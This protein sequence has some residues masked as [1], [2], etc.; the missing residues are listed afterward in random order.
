MQNPNVDLEKN[1]AHW[2]VVASSGEV[3]PHKFSPGSVKGHRLE[4]DEFCVHV[5]HGCPN[6]DPGS[7]CSKRLKLTP[8]SSAEGTK[9]SNMAEILP[10]LRTSKSTTKA[11]KR[12]III[13]K[14]TPTKLR[15]QEPSRSNAHGNISKEDEDEPENSS[16]RDSLISHALCKDA[17]TSIQALLKEKPNH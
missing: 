6:A 12:S 9:G 1:F 10:C 11:P 17:C 15:G 5:E 13:L 16:N 4:T 7:R 14:P 2:M 8:S 3:K